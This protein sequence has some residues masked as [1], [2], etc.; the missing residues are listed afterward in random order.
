MCVY[1]QIQIKR[2]AWLTVKIR[3]RV[4][5]RRLCINGDNDGHT[6]RFPKNGEIQLLF[7][8][9]SNRMESRQTGGSRSVAGKYSAFVRSGRSVFGGDGC[10]RKNRQTTPTAG[11]ITNNGPRIVENQTGN[12]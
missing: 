9:A 10:K 6:R 11:R 12:I 4:N 5:M 3:L 2:K 8:R 1:V 7:T